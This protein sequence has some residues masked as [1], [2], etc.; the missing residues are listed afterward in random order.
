MSAA[1]AHDAAASGRTVREVAM[2]K[3]DL[4]KEQLDAGLDPFKMT[5]PSE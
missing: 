1:I 4:T 5:A 2:E 3:T